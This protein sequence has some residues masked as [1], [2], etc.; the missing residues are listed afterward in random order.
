MTLD[1]LRYFQAVCK[2]GSI[3]G[4]SKK[5]NLSQPSISSAIANLEKE[6]NVKLFTRLPKK[7]TLTSAGKLLSELSDNLLAQADEIA[8]IMQQHASK[9]KV[10][11]LGVPP[12]IGSMLLPLLYERH[13][14]KHPDLQVHI[15]EDGSSVLKQL[16][17]DNQIDMAFLPHTFPFRDDVCALTI[18]E[19]QN[20]CCVNKAHPLAQQASIRLGDLENEPLVLFKNS[21]FQT[22]RILDEFARL[23]H[24]PNVLLDTT[25]LSTVEN[26]IR[27]ST[28][29]GFLFS[30]LIRDSS[31]LSGIPLDPPITTQVSL[32]W[33]K[34][35]HI[36]E[37][38][39]DL[40]SFFQA[41]KEKPGEA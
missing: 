2:C 22:E 21:F 7:I 4:A 33:K 11:R 38:M 32:V 17:S 37:E 16:L 24:K 18:T 23:G 20:V 14:K 3:S 36:S 41:N 15:T 35:R 27:N 1:Q 31:E 34:N 13:F 6:L 19:F 9:H 30:F 10:L 29:V 8:T 25:Q 26:M 28:A 5:I 40:I 39:N 12:M